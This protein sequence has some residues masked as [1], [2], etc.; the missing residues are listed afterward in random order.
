ML[1]KVEDLEGSEN[2]EQF[3]GYEHDASVSF[4]LSHNQPNTG[5]KLHKHPYEETFIVQE[6]DVLFTMGDEEIEAGPG[7]HR[8][9]PAR[10]PAQ[11]PEP[12]PDSP[13]GQ[14]P[15]GP[16][17]GDRVARVAQAGRIRNTGWPAAIGSNSSTGAEGSTA[18][19][20]RAPG[21]TAR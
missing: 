7:R 18:M 11:V 2:S 4:F 10:H 16:T 1:I 15:S 3:N 17:D 13:P 6:G 8:D 5:P 19:W 20:G 21:A 14:H 12:R 9:R